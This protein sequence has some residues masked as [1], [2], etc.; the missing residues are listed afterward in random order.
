MIQMIP[1]IVAIQDPILSS[2][3]FEIDVYMSAKSETYEVK[4]EVDE[5]T[6][7]LRAT[8]ETD[9]ILYCS[10]MPAR[11]IYTVFDSTTRRYRN[12]GDTRNRLH[13]VA[14]CN[15]TMSRDRLVHLLQTFPN[16]HSHLIKDGRADAVKYVCL[17]DDYLLS[18]PKTSPTDAIEFR[19]FN[20]TSNTHVRLPLTLSPTVRY[21]GT[22]YTRYTPP[23]SNY[24]P[25]IPIAPGSFET[26]TLV[27]GE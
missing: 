15:P 1:Q 4:H 2:D 25:S 12:I 17:P 18:V 23:W 7:R 19:L 13:V 20:H 3:H 5:I 26:I 14:R 6:E 10:I 8:F 11:D 9:D 22:S 27:W 16:V 24:G 21:N